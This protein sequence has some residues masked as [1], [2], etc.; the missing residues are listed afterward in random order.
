MAKILITGG[1]GYIGSHIVWA[2]H[3]IGIFPIILDDLSTGVK[4]CLPSD[5]AL[6]VGDYADEKRLSQIWEKEGNIASVIHMA[7]KISPEESLE[8]PLFYYEENTAKAVKLLDF[9]VK[10][11][12]SK[13]I[14]SSTAAVYAPSE[15]GYV[16][17]LSICKPATAYGASKYMTEQIIQDAARAYGFH[18]A[19]LRYFNVAGADPKGRTGQN[20]PDAKSLFAMMTKAVLG[21][22][23]SFDIYGNDYDTRDGTCIRDYIHVQDLAEAHLAALDYLDRTGKS[24]VANCGYGQGTSVKEAIDI[25]KE[26]VTNQFDVKIK[27]RRPG[28]LPFVVSRTAKITNEVGWHPRHNDLQE[29]I[30]DSVDWEKKRAQR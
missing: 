6:Y 20:D 30:R 16:D 9:C 22:L 5:V 18:Y 8:K 13:F 27:P 23:E 15:D 25:T 29:I 4:E 2:L 17:E 14:F 26:A 28:D 24:I 19:I 21:Q 7:G 1:A 10:K 12:V 11:K 3:D